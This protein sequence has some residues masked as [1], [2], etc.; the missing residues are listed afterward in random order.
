MDEKK[1]EQLFDAVC[2]KKR[3]RCT[4]KLVGETGQVDLIPIESTKIVCERIIFP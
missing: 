1:I 4:C 3:D 2:G